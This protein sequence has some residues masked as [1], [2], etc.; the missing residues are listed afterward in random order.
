MKCKVTSDFFQIDDKEY[1]KGDVIKVSKDF[2]EQYKH[3]L[4]KTKKGIVTHGKKVKAVYFNKQ[5]VKK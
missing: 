2:Y 4:S 5:R 1:K 3:S